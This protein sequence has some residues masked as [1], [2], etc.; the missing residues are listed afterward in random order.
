MMRYLQKRFSLFGT[1]NYGYY[2]LRRG[3]IFELFL[4]KMIYS[5]INL[6]T[7]SLARGRLRI[8]GG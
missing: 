4:S 5:K 1:L 2:I 7:R 6:T 8:F 3:E